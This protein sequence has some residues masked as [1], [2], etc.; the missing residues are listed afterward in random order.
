MIFAWSTRVLMLFSYSACLFSF[1]SCSS[2][3]APDSVVEQIPTYSEASPLAIP[4]STEERCLLA[5]FIVQSHD[6]TWATQEEFRRRKD[7]ELMGQLPSL[8]FE[9]ENSYLHKVMIPYVQKMGQN[10]EQVRRMV[11]ALKGM[12]PCSCLIDFVMDYYVTNHP[13]SYDGWAFLW[14]CTEWE[15]EETP[16]C[17]TITSS[18]VDKKLDQSYYG[19]QILHLL[20]GKC[21]R[22]ND[23]KILEKKDEMFSLEKTL[24]P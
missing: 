23:G 21:S 14:Y 4:L 6:W 16:H 11:D 9:D 10:P 17:R 2:S 3:V 7:R 20:E 8:A 18:I 19:R 22:P 5:Q 24:V 1:S 12:S 15:E 13:E